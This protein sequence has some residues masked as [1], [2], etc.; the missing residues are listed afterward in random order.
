MRVRKNTLIAKTGKLI[1][2]GKSIPEMV[3]ALNLPL[4]RVYQLR[5]RAKFA[6]LKKAQ[7]PPKTLPAKVVKPKIVVEHTLP[8]TVNDVQVGGDHYKKHKIQPWDAIHDWNL[9]FFTG[10]AVK[11]I[12]RHKDKGGL[13][14]IKKARH[15]LDKLISM[16]GDDRGTMQPFSNP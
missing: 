3:A 1:R 14:D 11:Y 8:P 2:E 12:A 16:N 13:E 5:S 7:T 6:M 4:Q 9:G 15:Y 10:N